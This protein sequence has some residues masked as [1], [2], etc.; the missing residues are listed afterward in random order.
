MATAP[1]PDPAVTPDPDPT[2][3]PDPAPDPKGKADPTPT[4]AND[5]DWRSRMA[6]DDPDVLKFLGRHQ[7]EASAIKEF[8]QLHADIRSGKY[9]K[10]LG[11]DPTEEE[12]ASYRKDHG[13]PETA[14]GYFEKLPEGLTIGEDDK[15]YVTEFLGKM[16]GVNAPPAL[17]NAAIEA[18]FGILEQQSA[19]AAEAEAT[20]K[21][22]SEDVLR[23]EWK[24]DY[25]RNINAT[26]SYL[27]T[28]PAPVKE[29][30]TQ[31]FGADGVALGN[32]AEVLKW[33]ASLALEANPLATVVPGA[34][35]NQASAIADEIAKIE[36]VMRTDRKA[37]NRDEAMQ[38]RLRELYAAQEKLN[39]KK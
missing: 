24:G 6:G 28:L 27:D 10:P 15:P 29:A 13:I 31:G 14:E 25:R 4:P 34:G 17:T 26:E 39:P 18:Y 5:D 1:A 32:N 21:K 8:K 36:N 19:E 38:A 7:S 37:Y 16:H 33:L 12:L 20:A 2:P 30:L 9:L 23:E 3:T 35:S 22:A 11:E